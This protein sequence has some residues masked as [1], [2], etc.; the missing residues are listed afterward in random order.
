MIGTS[1]EHKAY[2]S[3]DAWYSMDPLLKHNDTVTIVQEKFG[4]GMREV[5]PRCCT[6]ND[7]DRARVRTDCSGICNL[8]RD[9][10]VVT[11]V[12]KVPGTSFRENIF[13]HV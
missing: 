7:R 10:R 2:P 13:D 9:E 3:Y 8:W 1:M 11:S 4:L 5:R 6:R 12:L